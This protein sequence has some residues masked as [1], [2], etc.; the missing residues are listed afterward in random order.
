MSVIGIVDDRDDVREIMR[1]SVRL[2]LP[3]GWAEI[4]ISPLNSLKDYPSW[5]GQNEIVALIIDER[6]NEA[7]TN[8]GTA[9]SYEGHNLVDYMRR[10]MPELPIFVVTSFQDDPDL[11]ERFRHVEDIIER[12]E[13]YER[14]GDYIS[15]ITRAGQRYLQTFEG[16]LAELADFAKKSALG[17][18]ISDKEQ[19]RAKAIQTKLEMAFPIESIASRGEWLSRMEQLIAEMETLKSDIE[20]QIGEQ[21]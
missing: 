10:Y 13:F 7:A 16:E 6:L 18:S 17:E 4:D 9:V 21:S 15:R 14:P 2:A 8:T 3:Q 20:Q 12:N 19:E 1:D 11:R 5:I